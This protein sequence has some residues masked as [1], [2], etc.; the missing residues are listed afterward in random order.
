MEKKLL[1]LGCKLP[2]VFFVSANRFPYC[3]RPSASPPVHLYYQG[4]DKYFSQK[5]IADY[6]QNPIHVSIMIK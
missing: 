5:E 1:L 3:D 4:A 6:L 2:P